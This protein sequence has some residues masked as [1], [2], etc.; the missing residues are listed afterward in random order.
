MSSADTQFSAEIM[1]A[2]AHDASGRH[3]EAVDQLV[4]GVKKG[5]VEA[6]TRLGKRLLVGDRAPLLPNDGARFLEDAAGRVQV[7]DSSRTP[8]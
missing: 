1:A 5:D 4:A 7:R 6:T 8:P 2:E 3:A